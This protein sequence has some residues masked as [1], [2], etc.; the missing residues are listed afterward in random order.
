MDVIAYSRNYFNNG[1]AKQQACAFEK[2]PRC[3]Q[4]FEKRKQTTAETQ[5]VYPY[6]RDNAYNTYSF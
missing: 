3:L 6:I 2:G 1:L 4:S 5:N